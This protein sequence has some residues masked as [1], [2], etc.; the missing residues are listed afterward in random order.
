MCIFKKSRIFFT[1]IIVLLL[2]SSVLIN[3]PATLAIGSYTPAAPT[4]DGA[5]SPGEWANAEKKDFDLGSGRTG[6]IYVM[7]DLTNLYMALEISD[8][9]TGNDGVIFLF[10]DDNDGVGDDWA[11]YK[12]A[13]YPAPPVGYFDRHGAFALDAHADGVMASTVAAGKDFFELSKPLNSGDPEDISVTSLFLPLKFIMLFLSSPGIFVYPSGGGWENI[14][15]KQPPWKLTIQNVRHPDQ[16]KVGQKVFISLDVKYELLPPDTPIRM[17]ITAAGIPDQT[18]DQ[19]LSNNGTTTHTFELTAPAAPTTWAVTIF[20][21]KTP[22]PGILFDVKMISIEVKADLGITPEVEGI[23]VWK[24]PPPPDTAPPSK[25]L[26]IPVEIKY[27]LTYDAWI[28]VGIYDEGG[29]LVST[30]MFDEKVSGAGTNDYVFQVTTPATEGPWN[31]KVSLYYGHVTG[32]DSIHKD[33]D[34]LPFTIIVT[35]GVPGGEGVKII[36]V[37]SPAEVN[38]T[39]EAKVDVQVEYDLPAGSKYRASILD[40]VS[41]VVIKMSGEESAASHGFKTFSFDKIYAPFVPTDTT[42]KL[43]AAAEYKKPGEDWKILDPEGKREF[44]IMVRGVTVPSG[45]SP[46]GPAIPPLPIPPDMLPPAPAAFDFTLTV[47]PSTQEAIPGQAAKYQATV[48]GAGNQTQL[49]MLGISGYPLGATVNMA[50]LAGT[51]T[52]T[53]NLDIT[54]GGSVQPGTYSLN[55]NATGGGKTH[56]Q[57]VSLTIKSPPDF[58]ISLSAQEV[59][60]IRGQSTSLNLTAQPLHG[61]NSPVNLAAP[62]SPSGVTVNFNPASGTPSFASKIDVKVDSSVAA[63]TYPLTITAKGSGEK[64]AQVLLSVEAPRQEAPGRQPGFPYGLLIIIVILILLSALIAAKR[65]RKP[66]PKAERFCIECGAKV[67]PDALH[68]PKCGVKQP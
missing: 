48:T 22:G 37:E 33:C 21:Y 14:D 11:I 41:G 55:V 40:S 26:E 46:T 10:D 52:Y 47:T 64:T 7:N 29:V 58:S 16:V 13:G 5:I 32:V 66:K 67:P 50:P 44:E 63:G 60:V 56:S 68:C 25:P 45:G 49:V 27:A 12:Q 36:D 53:S 54:L 28:N 18:Y 2:L 19:T 6:T 1:V 65:R 42:F 61:F 57:T 31:L 3:I 39:A 15:L 9:H 43:I 24:G 17:G 38:S 4:I 8:P 30:V 62:G 34:E 51:P 20:V 59:R 35:S 23:C